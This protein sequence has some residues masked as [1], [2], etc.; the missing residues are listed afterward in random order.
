[1]NESEKKVCDICDEEFTEW[2]NHPWPI[3][4]RDNA[5]CCD[6]CNSKFVIPARIMGLKL[7]Q[8]LGAQAPF[9]NAMKREIVYQGTDDNPSDYVLQTVRFELVVKM[10]LSLQDDDG[11]VITEDDLRDHVEEELSWCESRIQEDLKE[12]LHAE[13]NL[14]NHPNLFLEVQI[15]SLSQWVGGFGPLFY[16]K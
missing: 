2:G 14:E 12:Y 15:N 8:E 3:I 16:N 10:P 4:S 5:V 6:E 9:Y 7:N 1:M 11:D 13:H